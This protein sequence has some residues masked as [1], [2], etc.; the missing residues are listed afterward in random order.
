[1]HP[2]VDKSIDKTFKNDLPL[3]MGQQLKM[4]VTIDEVVL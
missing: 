3:K 1:V 2:S 4:M